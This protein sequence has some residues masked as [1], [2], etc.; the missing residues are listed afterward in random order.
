MKSL[1]NFPEHI[2]DWLHNKTFTDLT[3]EEK[4]EVQ[5]LM[6][7]QEY[8]SYHLMLSDFKTLDGKLSEAISSDSPKPTMKPTLLKRIVNYP[9]PLYQ[10][11]AM[12]LI[13][14]LMKCKSADQSEGN[15]DF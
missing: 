5:S 3:E 7:P 15:F 14:V 1:E 2:F 13:L 8:E 12:F 9:I 11:A 4:F 6:S 10:V